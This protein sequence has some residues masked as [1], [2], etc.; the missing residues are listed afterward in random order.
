MVGN[1]HSGLASAA[2]GVTQLLPWP[3]L[4][5]AEGSFHLKGQVFIIIR[6]SQHQAP[7]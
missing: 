3:A 2:E 4:S 7:S 1:K 6:G 5:W